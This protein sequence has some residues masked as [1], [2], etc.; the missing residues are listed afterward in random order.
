MLLLSAKIRKDT[1]K[2]LKNLREKEILPA[3]LYGSK[4]KNLNLELNLK[5]F[6]KVYKEAGESS[7]VSLN[8]EGQKEKFLVLIH[9]IQFAPLSGKP[10]HVDLYQPALKEEVKV[11]VPIIIEGKSL[12]V[13]NLEG[14]LVKNITDIEIRALP[15][16][17]P[18]EIKVNV[19]R[20]KTFDDYILIKDLQ[21]PEGVKVVR[22]P[23]EILISVSPPEKVEEEK[24]AEEKPKEEEK[25]EEEEKIEEK[26]IEEKKKEP[27]SAK[28]TKGE[29]KGKGKTN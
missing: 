18:K 6:E 9:D 25:K 11:T 14:T 8:V 19:E 20:L 26:K 21:L 10:I 28:A 13:K 1:K 24:P 5:E 2:G 15:Q 12:A 23:E 4:I 29:G 3:V 7:L 22:D 17:L 27:F 16:K